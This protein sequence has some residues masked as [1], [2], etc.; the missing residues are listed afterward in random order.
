MSTDSPPVEVPGAKVDEAEP[1]APAAGPPDPDGFPVV[2]INDGDL[3]PGSAEAMGKARDDHQATTDPAKRLPPLDAGLLDPERPTVAAPTLAL[4]AADLSAPVAPLATA[5]APVAQVAPAPAARAARPAPLA[6]TTPLEPTSSPPT[7]FSSSPSAWGATVDPAAGSGP[8]DLGQFSRYTLTR[9]L[10]AGGMAQIFEAAITGPGGFS[11]KVVL[12]MILPEYATLGDFKE[13]F[14]NE[15]RVAALLSHP[16]IVHTFD[17][18]EVGGR[19]FI[20]MEYVDGASLQQVL[21][22]AAKASIILGPR[23]ALNVGVGIAR[24]LEYVSRLTGPNG[25]PLDVVHRDITPGNVLVSRQGEVK[26]T[27]FGVVKSTL[28]ATGTM[29]GTVKGK[30]AY[31]SPEQ[32]MGERVDHRSDLFSL[33]IVL[34]EVATQR[35]LFKRP[36]ITDT[37]SAVSQ[38]DVPRITSVVPG[39][40]SE[41]ETIIMRLL[42]GDRRQRYQ[43]ATDLLRDLEAFRDSRQWT[44]TGREVAGVFSSIFPSGTAVRP[45]LGSRSDTRGQEPEGT[46]P[47]VERTPGLSWPLIAGGV[48]LLALLMTIIWLVILD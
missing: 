29:A 46:M 2:E 12:K 28:N 22:G 13:M 44:V 23:M 9:S 16:N 43:T 3:E 31:M 24:A 5:V 36:T 25:E 21:R 38:A 8:K 1:A 19:L 48:G 41:L 45:E 42:S 33:G 18:G 39:F 26:L 7:P 11:K 15:A 4:Q 35:R 17:F 34:W 27:D 47:G 32:V 20:A 40:P 30:Y 6:P 10:G 14:V 37:M